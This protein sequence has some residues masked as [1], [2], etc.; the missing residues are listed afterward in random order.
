LESATVQLE[1]DVRRLEEE[2]NTVLDGIHG[3]VGGLSDIR[4]G[5]LANTILPEQVLDDLAM[6]QSSCKS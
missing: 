2:A 3:I 4:Y 6:L 1:E 5:R